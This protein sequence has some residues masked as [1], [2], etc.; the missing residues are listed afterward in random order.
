M[1]KGPFSIYASE[2]DEECGDKGN[3]TRHCD[4]SVIMAKTI[5][6]NRNNGWES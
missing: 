3:D 1:V 4:K 5:M 6:W 2:C